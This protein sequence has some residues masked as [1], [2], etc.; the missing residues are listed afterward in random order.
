[1]SGRQV[2]K[3]VEKKIIKQSSKDEIDFDKQ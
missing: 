3:N 1:L 2:H